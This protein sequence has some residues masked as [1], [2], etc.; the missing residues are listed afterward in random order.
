MMGQL[1]R[2]V[3]V[4]CGFLSSLVSVA[5]RLDSQFFVGFDSQHLRQ[6]HQFFIACDIEESLGMRLPASIYALKADLGPACKGVFFAAPAH[7]S[8][9][10]QQVSNT[11]RG[12]A[13]SVEDEFRCPNSGYSIDTRVHDKRPQGTSTRMQRSTPVYTQ[14][15]YTR[16]RMRR[17]I[18]SSLY[19]R[20]ADCRRTVFAKTVGQVIEQLENKSVVSGKLGQV[21]AEHRAGRPNVVVYNRQFNYYFQKKMPSPMHK[22]A[23]K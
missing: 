13:L 16:Q 19:A 8:A 10:Q 12:M 9:S 21:Y 11:L 6:V 22:A 2:F 15:L 23:S 14:P 7:P 3:G 17:I 18:L 20:L 5:S 4:G 1:E